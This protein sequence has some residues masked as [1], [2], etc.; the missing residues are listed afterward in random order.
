M[1]R[2]ALLAALLLIAVSPADATAPRLETVVE[3]HPFV[4]GIARIHS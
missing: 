4:P 3:L 2:A 1:I